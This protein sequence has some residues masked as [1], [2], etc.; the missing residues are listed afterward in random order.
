MRK[1]HAY[2]ANRKPRDVSYSKSYKLLQAVGEKKLKQL[3]IKD[4]MYN[5]SKILSIEL[6][7]EISPYVVRHMRRRYNLGETNEK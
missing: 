7:Q 1:K 3:F 6:G 4:G 5:V 2:P